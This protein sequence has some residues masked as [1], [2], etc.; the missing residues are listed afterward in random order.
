[1]IKKGIRQCQN[2]KE[3]F[4]SKGKES[5]GMQ[6]VTKTQF[7][8]L[9]IFAALATLL[10]FAKIWTCNRAR[11]FFRALLCHELTFTTNKRIFA[12]LGNPSFVVKKA[13][14][15]PNEPRRF[16]LREQVNTFFTNPVFKILRSHGN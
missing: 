11:V 12:L 15:Q 9:G 1:M 16:I 7:L 5:A 3:N 6:L 13:Q 14:R 4:A 10:S 8:K 2:A